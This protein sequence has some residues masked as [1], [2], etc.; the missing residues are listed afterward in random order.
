LGVGSK[1]AERLAS[2][3][4]RHLP[5]NHP[6]AVSSRPSI[7]IVEDDPVV[8]FAIEDYLRHC[9]YAVRV[10]GTVDFALRMLEQYAHDLLIA[11]L[12]LEGTDS[13]DGL[14]L[15]SQSLRRGQ[16][17]HAILVTAWSDDSTVTRA[18]VA[19][20]AAVVKKPA[21]LAELAAL[22]N[23]IVASRDPEPA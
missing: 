7:L 4:G 11:D 8:G 13:I 6:A 12:R 14:E 1:E 15:A 3:S 20:V 23:T 22:I 9:G 19:G 21:P 2:P 17:A 10:A 18:A 5:C 16:V